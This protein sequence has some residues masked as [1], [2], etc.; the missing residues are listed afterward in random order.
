MKKIIIQFTDTN[1]TVFSCN[2]HFGTVLVFHD[3][4]C[5]SDPHLSKVT[6]SGVVAD[7]HGLTQSDQA[8]W[9]AL[10]QSLL[11]AWDVRTWPWDLTQ[12]FVI[13]TARHSE[14]NAGN[15]TQH[16]RRR[17]SDE[18]GRSSRPARRTHPPFASCEFIACLVFFFLCYF[19]HPKDKK[20]Q[21]FLKKSR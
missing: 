14:A 20:K 15:N 16:A 13:K 5:V 17:Q 2:T 21:F 4:L 3:W 12:P 7:T 18:T 6:T 9:T 19:L 8:A 11:R 10:T 1:D